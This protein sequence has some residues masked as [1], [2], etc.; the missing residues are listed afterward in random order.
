MARP[1]SKGLS[2]KQE[3]VLVSLRAGMHPTAIAEDMGIS[4]N[5]VYQHIKRIKEAGINFPPVARA[6][7]GR[8]PGKKANVKNEITAVALTRQTPAVSLDT[9]IDQER[10]DGSNRL[11]EIA[12]SLDALTAEK[13]RLEDRDVRLAKAQAALKA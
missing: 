5:G 1:K 9:Q 11:E 4:R 13:A 12:W 8:P 7:R 2:S 6:K 10:A 3:R